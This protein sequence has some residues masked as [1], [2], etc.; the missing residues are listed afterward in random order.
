VDDKGIPPVA[1]ITSPAAG[2][3]IVV[4]STVHVQVAATDD[5]R[6]AAVNFLV[7]GN[8]V[9][10]A[11]SLPY[12]F[13]F[14][15][16]LTTGPLTLGASAVDLGGN[17]GNAANVV[18]NVIPDP[19]TTVIGRVVDS[20]GNPIAGATVSILTFTGTT[21]TNGTFSIPG[22]PTVTGNLA[23]SA[24]A[25]VNG[26]LL[27]G[28]SATVA[29]VVGG[30]TNVGD[31]VVSL[32]KNGDFET[33]TL[34]GWD[35]TPGSNAKVISSLGPVGPFTPI[36]PAQGQF[37]AFL[38]NAAN[39]STPPG[40]TGSIISQTFTAPSIPSQISFCYQ[41]VSNDSGGFEDFFLAQ[42]V[43][44]VGTFD[45]G[46]ADNATGSPAGGSVA[47]PPP[48]LSQGVVLT[49]ATAPIFASQVNILGSGLFIISTSSMTNRVCSA[50]PIPT[51]VLGTQ[52]TLRFTSGN[53][54][55]SSVESAVVVD[56]VAV[57]ALPTGP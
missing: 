20:N 45:L 54:L 17:V 36:L 30:T 46:A 47:P 40:T 19:G 26:T 23:V 4:G 9:F 7:N 25:L 15:A 33:G 2:S 11:T 51:A 6:V 43:T 18:V 31:I 44:G 14:T 35:V 52:V 28:R 29:P 57:Q 39:A 41:F 24:T 38:S 53:A 22:V 1:A 21:Q 13:T 55:D 48:D 50:F 5:V 16:P 10:T 3:S 8:I 32:L 27:T 12:E 49:P 34:S 56:A 42:L 37:M